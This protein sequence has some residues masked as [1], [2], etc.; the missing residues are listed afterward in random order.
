MPNTSAACSIVLQGMDTSGKDGATKSLMAGH[1]TIRRQ[2]HKFQS[3]HARR[4]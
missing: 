1:Y 2:C 3:A 4:A